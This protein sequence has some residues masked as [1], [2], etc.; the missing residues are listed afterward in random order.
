MY[1][2]LPGPPESFG[3]AVP[4]PHVGS[5]NTENLHVA[6]FVSHPDVQLL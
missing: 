5:G 4:K 6:E 2:V 3:N 1:K